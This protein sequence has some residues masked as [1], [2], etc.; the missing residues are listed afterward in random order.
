MFQHAG[1]DAHHLGGRGHLPVRGAERSGLR[2]GGARSPRGGDVR[3]SP[4]GAAKRPRGNHLLLRHPAG[5]EPTV[6]QRREGHR[7]L[8]SLHEG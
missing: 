5:V 3:G 6:L 7:L 8:C 4:R 2:A 1:G